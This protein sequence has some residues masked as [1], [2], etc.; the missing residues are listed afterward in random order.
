MLG[1]SVRIGSLDEDFIGTE[2]KMPV[3][4]MDRKAPQLAAPRQNVAQRLQTLKVAIVER[5]NLVQVRQGSPLH[6]LD[7][8][9]HDDTSSL[10]LRGAPLVATR[11]RPGRALDITYTPNSLARPWASAQHAS[12]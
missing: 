5:R 4:E 6:W 3:G 9:R 7:G 12:P 11:A 1:A 8:K 10:A 2:G